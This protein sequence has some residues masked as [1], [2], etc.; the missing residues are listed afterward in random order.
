MAVW[1]CAIDILETSYNE[2]KHRKVV[3]QGWPLLGDLRCLIPLVP[4]HEK[5]FKQ[6]VQ[7]MGDARYAFLP[8][9]RDKDRDHSRAPS[10]F[11]NLFSMQRGDLVVGIE[12][13]TVRGICQL[14]ADADV[15]YKHQ[16]QWEYGQTR[17]PVDWLDWDATTLGPPPQTPRQ[18]VHGI[19]RLN[20]EEGTVA[21]AW[22]RLSPT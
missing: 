8:L 17:F 3:A 4:D 15:Q 11:W 18:S 1:W 12:G 19:R 21:A 13:T 2:C 9:W 5:E 7:L 6:V 14:D 16:P 22:R 20:Q 10:V